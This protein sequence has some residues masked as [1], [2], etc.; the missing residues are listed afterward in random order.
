MLA[1]CGHVKP[2]PILHDCLLFVSFTKVGSK[3]GIDLIRRLGRSQLFPSCDTLK[4]KRGLSIFSTVN[5]RFLFLGFCVGD[6]SV[7]LPVALLV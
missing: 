1:H 4:A 7:L 5:L 6:F 3:R 2:S